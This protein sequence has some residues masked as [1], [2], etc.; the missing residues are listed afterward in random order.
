[1]K[2]MK[3]IFVNFGLGGYAG[4]SVSMITIIRQLE[5]K[6]HEVLLVT[7]DGDGY[8]NNKT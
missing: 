8:Y 6:G 7:T 4:D 5:K 3:I 1:M 2:K